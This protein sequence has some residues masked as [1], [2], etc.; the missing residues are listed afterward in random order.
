MNDN[1]AQLAKPHVKL[2]VER[3]TFGLIKSTLA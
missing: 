1:D 2:W 3:L